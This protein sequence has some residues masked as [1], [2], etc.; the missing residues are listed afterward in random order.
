MNMSFIVI[1]L[2]TKIK[3]EFHTPISKVVERTYVT[4]LKEIQTK[5][6]FSSQKI[7]KNSIPIL[8]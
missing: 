6:I 7:L 8:V 3:T 4:F 1:L 5:P 2:D